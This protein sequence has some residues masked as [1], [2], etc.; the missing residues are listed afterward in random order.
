MAWDAV[1]EPMVEYIDSEF[2]K[3][4]DR[5][6]CNVVPTLYS[7]VTAANWD[8]LRIEFLNDLSKLETIT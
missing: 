7:T 1:P 2:S 4:A 8:V 5:L 3:H 6:V